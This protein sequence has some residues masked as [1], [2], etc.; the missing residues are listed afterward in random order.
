[1]ENNKA[2]LIERNYNVTVEKVW[3]AITDKN[4]MKHLTHE[5]LE[6]FPKSNP[7]FAKENFAEG[8]TQILGKSLPD[9]LQKSFSREA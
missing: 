4:E 8:W 9:Y 5:G 7:D 2:F 3:K 1:M 6:S